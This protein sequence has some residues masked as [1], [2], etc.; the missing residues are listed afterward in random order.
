MSA[1]KTIINAIILAAGKGTRMKSSLLKVAHQVAGKPIIRYVI[2]AVDDMGVDHIY[3]VIGHQADA[4]KA[5]IQHPKTTYILQ[6]EQLGTGH[7]VMQVKPNIDLTANDANDS[8][9]ILAG[10]CPLLTS[11]TLKNVVQTH[12][13]SGAAGT[14]LT[15]KMKNPDRYGRILREKEGAVIGI[16]E[17]KDCTDQVRQI[18][19]INTGAYVFN[20]QLLFQSLDKVTT[21]NTQGEY[22]LTDVIHILKE[23]GHGVSAYCMDN[24]DQAIGIN[25]RLDLAKTNK[26]LYQDNNHRLMES[27]VTIIDPN[28]TFIDT[29]VKIGQD[30]VIEPFTIIKEHTVIGDNC[31]IGAYSYISNG[32]IKADSVLTPYTII[33]NP[34]IPSFTN[35]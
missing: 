9:I 5:L 33:R 12:Q 13:E 10:D 25:T 27:G 16:K 7:A 2:D 8:V 14:I 19:E 29:D 28:S 15:T 23:S 3:M 35:A 1:Q 32:D 20:Q 34:A 30:T 11:Q 4:L 18:N 17:A 6:A 22:Y 21:Q 31:V 24:P 26:T